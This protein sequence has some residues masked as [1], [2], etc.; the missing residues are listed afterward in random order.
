MVLVVQNLPANAG[1]VRDVGWEHPLEEHRT[2]HSSIITQ[3]MPWTENPAGCGP[4]DG[5]ESDTTGATQQAYTV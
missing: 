3:R 4:Q 5:K 1:G 2:T